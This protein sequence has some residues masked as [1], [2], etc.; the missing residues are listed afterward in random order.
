ML[1][2]LHDAAQSLTED[3]VID[4]LI[5]ATPSSWQCEM[6]HQGFDPYVHDIVNAI[7]FA[8]QIEAAESK[9]QNSSPSKAHNNKSSFKKKSGYKSGRSPEKT[10]NSEGFHCLH[11]GPNRTHDTNDC[12]FL[13]NQS[14]RAKTGQSSSG[15][16]YGSQGLVS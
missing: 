6:E 1:P 10:G 11:H 2:P 16:D 13:Q 15:K 3:E 4:I 9:D 7:D 8:E 5:Y 14:K 12:I